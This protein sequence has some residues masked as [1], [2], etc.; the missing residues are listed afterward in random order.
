[1]KKIITLGI[2]GLLISHMLYKVY[3][4]PDSGTSDML[5]FGATILA[6]AYI[7]F[8]AVAYLLPMFS[9]KITDMVFSDSGL[10]PEPDNLSKARGL[11]AQGEYESAITE[12]NRIIESEPENRLTWTG[13]AKIYADKL[14][15][16]ELAVATYRRAYD[17][18]EW[19]DEDAA[20]FLFRIS[21]WQLNE[22]DDRDAGIA[23]IEEVRAT[24][25]ETRHSANATN[26]LRQ[27]GIQP[28]EHITEPNSGR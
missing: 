17:N 9:G 26:Q 8:L 15:Q 21:E 3:S 18:A 19:S 27:L 14:E 11:V 13:I 5:R 1:M 7:G 28:I 10:A 20:F 6:G 12:Y 23:T 16:P 25:P 24:F 22:L 4:G 2:V